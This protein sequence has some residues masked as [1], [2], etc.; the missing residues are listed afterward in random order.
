MKALRYLN[1]FSREVLK[2]FYI[3]LNRF[4]LRLNNVHIGLHC[5]IYNSIFLLVHESGSFYIGDNFTLSS[6]HAFNPLS[7]NIKA[8][9]YVGRG[10]IL[11]IGNNVGMSSTCIEAH[12]SIIIGNNVKVGA[13]TT[14]FDT[15]SHSLDYMIRRTSDNHVTSQPIC[16][17][18]DVWIGMNCIILKGVTIGARSIIAS[19][20]VVTKSIPPDSIAGGIPAKVIKKIS[21]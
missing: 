1:L 14:I 12:T 9:I 11:K 18:D 3:C 8:S 5:K 7:R 10:A 21:I 16:I 20:S 6:G 2:Y 15:N 4:L 17:E 13:C 19:G